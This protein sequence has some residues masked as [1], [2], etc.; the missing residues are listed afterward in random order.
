M[1][2]DFFQKILEVFVRFQIVCLCGLSYAVD[3]CGGFGTIDRI[4]DLPVLLADAEASDCTLR[5][6]IV[7]RNISI[8]Q[9]YLRYFS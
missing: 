1:F 4:N 6:I 3:H 7:H 5:R 8:S 9:E 2:R